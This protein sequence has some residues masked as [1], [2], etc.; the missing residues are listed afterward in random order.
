[1]SNPVANDSVESP[2]SLIMGILGDVEQ[3][4]G[5]HLRLARAEIEEEVERH[6]KTVAMMAVTFAIL[7][8]ASIVWVLGLV[9]FMHAYMNTPIAPAAT[10]PLWACHMI[11]G[12][13]VGVI[14]G[15]LARSVHARIVE[16]VRPNDTNLD[17][18][19]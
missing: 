13:V 14:G 12:T 16:N 11:V 7:L 8:V 10:F 19:A 6:A 1:M 9:Y 17:E 3:L 2:S 18:K 4:A 5:Q 15:V